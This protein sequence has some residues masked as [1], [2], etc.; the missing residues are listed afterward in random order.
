MP[1]QVGSDGVSVVRLDR[2]R[3]V[4]A[5]LAAALDLPSVINAV[6]SHARDAL[7]AS[8]ATL[9]LLTEADFLTLVG[10]R[11]ASEASTTQWRRIP[12]TAEVPLTEAVRTR[13]MVIAAGGD[14]LRAR[15]PRLPSNPNYRTLVALPLIAAAE[16]V[17]VVGLTF[18]GDWDPDEREREYLGLFADTCAQAIRRVQATDAAADRAAKLALLVEAT[19]ELGSTLDYHETLR[20]VADLTIRTLGDWCAVQLLEDG[21]LR[22]VAVAHVDPRL[23]ELAQTLQERYPT[24]PASPV[25]SPNVV[26]TGLSELTEEITDEMLVAGSRDEEQLSLTRSLGLH[27]AMVVPLKS[28]DRTLGAITIVSAESGRRYNETDLAVAED[29]GRRAGAAI[30]NAELYDQTQRVAA[31]LQDAIL[32]QILPVIAGWSAET[33]YKP[34]G[35]T[36][37]GGDFYDLLPQP[38]GRFAVLIGDVMGRGISAAANMAQLSAAVRAYVA[39]DPTPSVLM[40]K[41]DL[42]VNRYSPEH[43][44]TLF[45]ALIDPRTGRAQCA[46]AGHLPPILVD[47]DGATPVPTALGPPLGVL[48]DDRAESEFTIAAGQ[49]LLLYTDGLIERRVEDLD[50]GMRRLV[51]NT[52]SLAGAELS[53]GLAAL[54]RSVGDPTRD[55]DVTMLALRRL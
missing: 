46:S 20:S 49:T 36:D 41:L 55:D 26:R 8:I 22:T 35:R 21:A 3:Q 2:F 1:L 17:G 34:A 16:T 18:P 38:D 54:Q 45:Y 5:E 14:E 7:G 40:S 50:V 51:E 39:I 52:P 23:V 32:P 44:S 6:V 53:Q 10:T 48:R 11:G 47:S 37:V 31:I 42:H 13:A 27:S 4:T 24:D 28:R 30:D 43:L 15:Y 25:G 19:R 29:L 9:L 12:L 33:S